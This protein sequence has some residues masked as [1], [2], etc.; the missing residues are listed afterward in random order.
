[1]ARDFAG[2][3]KLVVC[4]GDNIFEYAQAEAI[5]ALRTTDGASV[6]VS[7]VPDPEA[8]RRRRLR[9]GRRCRGHRREGG[10]RRHALRRAALERRGRRALLLSPDVFEIIDTLRA[11]E[12]RRAR[13]H[14]REPRARRAAGSF[15]SSA[16]RAGGTTAASTGPT[17]PTSGARS[18]R[19]AS[20]SLI[21]GAPLPAARGTRTSAAGSRA[22][23]LE[24]AAE[25]DA[26][27]EPRLVAQ[28]VIRGLHY[29]ERGQDDLFACLPGMVRV[30]VLDRDDRRDVHR[31]H[32]RRQPGRDL[33]PRPPRARLRGAHRLPLLLPRHRGVRRCRPGRARRSL[34]RPARRR[35]LE[36][37][38]RRFSR[39][40]TRP[41][42]P[43]HRRRGPARHR[44]R[45]GVSGGDAVDLSP[46]GTCRSRLPSS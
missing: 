28:G 31:G 23:P 15:A 12:P 32:R 37:D 16:C 19:R 27:G 33:R 14:G 13:D 34:E 25:A 30:V 4:L 39:S 46:N 1:M 10:H 38:D 18:R 45:R 5:S 40:G 9:R 2:G 7:E 29:H 42:R 8:F 26:A 11:V 35:P 41:R 36:H 3:D 21:D 24:R 22:R 6:F 44:A 20:T 43:D 17:S